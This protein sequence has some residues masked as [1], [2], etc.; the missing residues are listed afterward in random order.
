[1]MVPRLLR[2]IVRSLRRLGVCAGAHVVLAGVAGAHPHGGVADGTDQLAGA[3]AAMGDEAIA[4]CPEGA[5]CQHA[6]GECCPA[7]VP[8]VLAPASAAN[9]RGPES[10]AAR[11][12]VAAVLDACPEGQFRPPCAL[13]A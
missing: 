9:G 5:G 6:D 3:A 4:G 8:A 1:M 11:P 13:R 12:L 2:P 7:C 10:P